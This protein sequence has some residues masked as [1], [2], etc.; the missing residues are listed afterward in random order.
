[1]VV[2]MNTIMNMNIANTITA[3]ATGNTVDD[4]NPALP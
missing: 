3:I 2:I 1:M 4:V